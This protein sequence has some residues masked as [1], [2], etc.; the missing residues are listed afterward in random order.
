MI[1][2][3]AYVLFIIRHKLTQNQ[4]LL[5]YLL[6]K[7]RKD[8]IIKYKDA[9]PSDD[10]TMIGNY[11][12]DDLIKRGFIITTDT[13]LELGEEFLKLFVGR[14]EAAEEIFNLYPKYIHNNG[15]DI[16][17]TI[18]D[19]KSFAGIYY[20]AIGR[21]YDE[22]KEVKLDIQ[23]GIDNNLLSLDLEK[24]VKSHYWKVLR[25]LRLRKEVNIN[26][27]KEF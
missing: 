14:Y 4:F 20:D 7:K 2:E 25:E 26:E 23:Y 9:F 13:G 12:T 22:H 19:R 24:F 17:L 10:S 11:F 21:L 1:L 15:M 6:Y 18:M 3:D 5:L 27:E 16:P 8:L